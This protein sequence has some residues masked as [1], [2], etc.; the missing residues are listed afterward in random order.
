MHERVKS[1]EGKGKVIVMETWIL[2][3]ETEERGKLRRS[4]GFL[5][6]IIM[7]K[8]SLNYSRE[9]IGDFGS[10]RDFHKYT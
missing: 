9:K 4:M 2:E 3:Y 5:E 7:G 8:N 10:K 1:C 6:R